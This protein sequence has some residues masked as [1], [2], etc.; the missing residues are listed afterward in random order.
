M[1]DH[2]AGQKFHALPRQ[3]MVDCSCLAARQDDARSDLLLVVFQL[4][5]DRRWAAD[6]RI[7]TLL[8]VVPGLLLREERT[9]I[10][11]PGRCRLCRGV[12]RW[13]QADPLEQVLDEVPEMRL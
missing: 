8:D 1:R 4:L 2:L 10:L 3:L 12:S 13:R 6:N 11:D 5:A 7:D 9:A